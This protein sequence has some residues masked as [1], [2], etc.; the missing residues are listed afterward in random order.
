MLLLHD[1]NPRSLQTC[2]HQL[3]QVLTTLAGGQTL[4]VVRKA[5]AL[6]AHTR[7]A[8]IDEI[9]ADGLEPWLQN[10]MERLDRLGNA[11]HRQFMTAA[12]ATETRPPIKAPFRPPSQLQFQAQTPA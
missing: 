12:D 6:S 3:H 1:A 7:Y 8:R 5:G 2:T 10:A 4:E 11:I 9:L